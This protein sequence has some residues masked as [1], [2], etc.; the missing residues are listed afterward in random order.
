MK[1]GNIYNA[2]SIFITRDKKLFELRGVEFDKPTIFFG[3]LW[4]VFRDIESEREVFERLY[5]KYD[6]EKLFGIFIL[7]RPIFV[8]KDVNLAKQIMIQHFHNFSNF[9]G[10][11][12]H[13]IFDNYFANH[14]GCLEG[15]KWKNAKE[16]LLSVFAMANLK[17]LD[18]CFAFCVGKSLKHIKLQHAHV[19]ETIV[20]DVHE[21]INRYIGETIAMI[22]LGIETGS[23][24]DIVDDILHTSNQIDNEL[25]SFKTMMYLTLT[26]MMNF[27]NFKINLISDGVKH[28]FKQNVLQQ[29]EIRLKQQ[30][31]N[32]HNIMQMLIDIG[33]S[34]EKILSN[35]F[36]FLTGGFKST[37]ELLETCLWELMLNND[38]QSKII[39]EID[40][41]MEFNNTKEINFE[42]L[43]KM[44]NLNLF[45]MEVLRKYPPIHF[46]TRICT[47]DCTITT[48]DGEL[49]KFEQNDVI[50][51]PITLIQN[52]QKYF[53]NPNIFD[54]TRFSEKINHT[55]LLSFGLGPRK[56]LGEN[57]VILQA[58]YLITS[59]LTDYT[60]E[61]TSLKSSKSDEMEIQLT[62][63][64]R[65]S[66]RHAD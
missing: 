59:V 12:F 16:K 22:V 46:G 1:H 42:Q 7:H 38:I 40:E 15:D 51:I 57:F 41:C 43:N 23:R 36:M 11:N 63:R 49:L 54:P 62:R 19:G 50:Y 10:K 37:K 52:D 14:L 21:F 35:V 17:S 13:E 33:E 4:N 45:M 53:A 48:K 60:I 31:N 61:K 18:K 30:A 39:M 66:F 47:K 8:I 5:E 29:I 9:A 20:I 25:M 24:D 56:C 27:R 44:N 6:R 64:Y 2:F 3:N 58:K 32:K 34:S 55:N 65:Q 28:F 26:S